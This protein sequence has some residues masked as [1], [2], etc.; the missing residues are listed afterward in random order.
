MKL[1]VSATFALAM[2]TAGQSFAEQPRHPAED[3]PRTTLIIPSAYDQSPFD[4]N[5]MG[6]GSDKSD[7][8]GVPYYNRH[9][10]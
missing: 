5:H 7:A 8:L 2:L 1:L 10:L 4:F 3:S 9:S 6:T